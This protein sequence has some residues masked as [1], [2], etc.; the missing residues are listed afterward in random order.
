[1]DEEGESIYELLGPR[2]GTESQ[3]AK[4][5]TISAIGNPLSFVEWSAKPSS[6]NY[7]RRSDRSSQQTAVA[8]TSTRARGL[9]Q[10]WIPNGNAVWV[11]GETVPAPASSGASTVSDSGGQRRGSRW[12]A[13]PALQD[14]S[15]FAASRRRAAM[16]LKTAGSSQL[17]N[18][19]LRALGD[20]IL[21]VPISGRIQLAA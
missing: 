5:K 12:C 18:G 8:A 6:K 14:S 11:M 17:P 4:T 16:W 9:A 3:A 19:S 21:A 1:M 15:P 10:L 13:L 7:K 2:D 20:S